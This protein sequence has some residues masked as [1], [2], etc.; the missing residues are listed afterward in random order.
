MELSHPPLRLP[1]CTPLVG[2]VFAAWDD[3]DRA[4]D[5]LPES[6][7]LY[8]WEDGAGSNFAW[9]Y[10]HCTEL[11]D[12]WINLR[13]QGLVAHPFLQSGD[14]RAGGSGA[15]PD[16][17]AV[18]IAVRE[19]RQAAA[20]FLAPLAVADLART[21]PYAGSVRG[22][23]EHGRLSIEHALLRIVAHH[24][25]HIGEI[26][27]KRRLRGYPVAGDFPGQLT[28]ALQAERAVSTS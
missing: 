15:A 11:I 16:W 19:I 27:Y 9:T 26:E 25:L 6:E 13:L 14:F 18:V 21:V 8:R 24:Y 10:V 12:S 7:L 20:A 4:L 17:S 3:L 22:V 23:R 28:Q 1:A 2:T 5:D